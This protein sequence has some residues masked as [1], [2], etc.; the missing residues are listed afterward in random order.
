[1]CVPVT[2]TDGFKNGAET[3]ID[4]GGTCAAKCA[5][6][7]TCSIAADCVSGVCNSTAKTCTPASCTDTVHN[8]S[9]TDIDCGGTCATKCASGKACSV[10]ADCATGVC[11]GSVCVD[12][13]APTFFWFDATDSATVTKNGSN[14]VSEW[15]DKSG[16]GRHATVPAAF[17]STGPTWTDAVVNGKPALQFNGNQVRLMTAAVPTSSE[18]TVFAVFNMVSPYNWGTIVNQ[19]HDVYFSIRK[20]DCCGGG[21]N[22]NFHIQNNNGAPLQPITTNTWKL[23][24]T[25]RV[26][27]TSTMY[28]DPA[29]A[30]SFTGDTLTGG[31]TNA[32]CTTANGTCITLG[33]AIDGRPESMGGYT[34]EIRAFTSALSATSRGAIETE[35]KAKYGIP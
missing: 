28:Y 19:G 4:C 7:K 35:L 12:V 21:G 32:A 25:V 29:A 23:V 15:R 9:E 13:P 33:N 31:V 8:G 22:L 17:S 14:V 34:A 20:S 26:G 6:N 1:M 10:T 2:C 30:T 5:D 11:F 18:I 16:L 24:T 3:D 27:T